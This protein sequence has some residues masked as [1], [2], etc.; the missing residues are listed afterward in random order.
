MKTVI[1]GAGPTG[2]LVRPD[3]HTAWTGTER[4]LPLALR[5]H[6]GEPQ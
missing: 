5:R 4:D 1:V 6:L 2:L 3:G